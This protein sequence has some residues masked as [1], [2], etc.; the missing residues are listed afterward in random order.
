[1]VFFMKTRVT[2]LLLSSDSVVLLGESGRSW[3]PG[4]RARASVTL[5]LT[6]QLRLHGRFP[7]QAPPHAAGTGGRAPKRARPIRTI[8]E[9]AATA[10]SRSSLMPMERSSNPRRSARRPSVSKASFAA[11]FPG[12]RH[13]HEAPHGEPQIA[14]LR[15]ELAGRPRGAPVA[16]RQ[17]R[18]LDLHQDPCPRSEAGD[19]LALCGTGDALP[20]AHQRGEL[21]H[22]VPLHR[23][24]EVPGHPGVAAVGGRLAHAAPPRSSPP[25]PSA[26]PGA[27]DGPRRPEALRDADHADPGGFAAGA[28]DPLPDGEQP[29]C[30]VVASGGRRGRRN[31]R[32]PG[33]A[34]RPNPR[35]RRRRCPRARA[36]RRSSTPGH[37]PSMSAR[38]PL[39]SA[40]TRRQ[41]R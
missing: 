19:P 21:R 29:S 18:R 36:S 30:D 2:F 11:P 1:M 10:A 8:V 31:R 37:R 15:H 14:Q 33:P 38:H 22:F 27:A 40:R 6:P 34:P 5:L 16:A 32:L 4:T 13:R 7:G 12:R 35:W 24:E 17:A 39:P 28:L 41:S 20:E 23:T 3:R 9:P 25:G 26:P